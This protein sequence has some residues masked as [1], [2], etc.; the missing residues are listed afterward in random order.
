V[1]RAE[2]FD[3]QLPLES[4][5]PS[6]DAALGDGDGAARH[7]YLMWA[8]A[9][10]LVEGVALVRGRIELLMSGLDFISCRT[11]RWMQT[12][13]RFA[14]N[15]WSPALHSR[16]DMAG[17]QRGNPEHYESAH[18]YYAKESGA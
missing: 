7:P 5:V 18:H 10:E 16:K 15:F 8:N 13:A 3:K 9:R 4:S 14:K 12:F 1:Q 2:R 6:P 17:Q 11:A